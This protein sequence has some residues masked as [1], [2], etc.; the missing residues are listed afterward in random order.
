A[1]EKSLKEAKS[2]SIPFPGP[3]ITLTKG[4]APMST[5]LTLNPGKK[6]SESGIYEATKSNRRIRLRKGQYAP[7]TP[8]LG[9]EWERVIDAKRLRRSPTVSIA[10]ARQT[11]DLSPKL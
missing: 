2:P 6:V 10:R 11:P 5:S 4:A 7:L 1:S 3:T 9:E 8:Y